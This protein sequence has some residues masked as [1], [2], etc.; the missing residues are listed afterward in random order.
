MTVAERGRGERFDALFR[1]Y[2]PDMVAYCGWRSGSHADGQDAVAEVFL[3]AWRKLEEVPEG[4]EARLWLYG[5][6]RR[7]LANQARA[8]RRRDRLTVRAAETYEGE[9]APDGDIVA[10][11]AALSPAVTD[12]VHMALAQLKPTDKE[13]LLL[14]EWEGFTPSQI[15]A[16][17]G[18]PTVTARGRL[19]RARRRFRQVYEA[20]PKAPPYTEMPAPGDA[21]PR[22][23]RS[24][25]GV[26][27]CS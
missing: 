26:M 14:A 13:I 6:A 11:Q 8:G 9:A 27:R 12:A 10:H 17:M 15:A 20:L 2:L 3:T 4:D 25:Q 5:T 21:A 22:A 24:T 19:F 7:V 1:Q 16:V 18:C 23:S